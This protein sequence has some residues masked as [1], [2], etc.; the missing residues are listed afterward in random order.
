MTFNLYISKVFV[1]FQVTTSVWIRS[2]RHHF[3]PDP[4]PCPF[5]P[6]GKRNYFFPEN[7]KIMSKILKIMTPMMLTSRVTSTAVNKSPKKSGFQAYLKLGV[8]PVPDRNTD[9][10]KNRKPDPDRHRNYA[11]PQQCQ[12]WFQLI[13]NQH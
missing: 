9:W 1:Q 13:N 3:L 6:N 10:H 12:H 8:G 7:F 5:Q 11:D 4:D 2:D